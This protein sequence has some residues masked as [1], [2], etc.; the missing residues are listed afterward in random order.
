[1]A[2]NDRKTSKER[3]GKSDGSSVNYDAEARAV[4]KEQLDRVLGSAD[5]TE[6]LL[7]CPLRTLLQIRTTTNRISRYG[8]YDWGRIKAQIGKGDWDKIEQRIVKAVEERNKEQAKLNLEWDA[9]QEN[10][11][12]QLEEQ[13]EKLTYEAR[14]VAGYV[15]TEIASAIAY[16]ERFGRY[17]GEWLDDPVAA[18]TGQGGFGE[19]T[20]EIAGI[21]LQINICL[22]ISNSMY[23]NGLS[24]IAVEATRNI[25][26]ALKMASDELPS[27]SLKVNLWKWAAREDGRTVIN[28]VDRQGNDPLGAA[29]MLPGKGKWDWTGEDTWI[30][31][32]LSRLD[33]W[34]NE[35][36]D[37]GAYRLDLIISDGVLEHKMDAS[38][39][40][41]IQDRRDGNL[42][43][44]ILNFLPMSEWANYRVPNKCVQYPVT[45]ETLGSMLRSVLGSWI[46]TI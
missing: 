2:Y 31:P 39:G 41:V 26:L 5:L 10:Y 23:Y 6:F 42:Q 14:L 16:K 36:G 33:E 9:Q 11:R 28:C 43:S 45:L 24:E 29:K 40:D 20:K 12:R 37:P 18:M 35:E 8:Q 15:Q 13:R 27:G 22:D 4:S 17:D 3:Y 19:E 34:E 1:M 32:L 44:V 30:H 25:Y 38:R 21:K 46:T 7:N